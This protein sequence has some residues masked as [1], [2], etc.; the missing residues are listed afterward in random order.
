MV[1]LELQ[2]VL[3]VLVEVALLEVLGEHHPL[4]LVE[5]VLA[6]QEVE[7]PVVAVLHLH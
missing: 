3:V 5:E 7:D 2:V 4:V 6:A 1:P